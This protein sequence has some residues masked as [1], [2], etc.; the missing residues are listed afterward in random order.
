MKSEQTYSI[1][2][3]LAGDAFRMRIAAVALE[4]SVGTKECI[5]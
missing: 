1:L 4:Q 2:E 3:E 5:E